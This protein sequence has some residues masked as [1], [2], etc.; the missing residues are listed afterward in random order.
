MKEKPIQFDE[1]KLYANFK[2]YFSLSG[3]QKFT[4]KAGRMFLVRHFNL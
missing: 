1:L 4:L 2:P 3:M